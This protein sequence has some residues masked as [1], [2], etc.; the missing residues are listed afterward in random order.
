M[1]EIRTLG[2]VE[3]GEIRTLGRV[4]QGEIHILG[5][6]VAKID[7]L[8]QTY[9]GPYEVIP[10]DETQTLS[11]NHLRM[12]DD[13]TVHPIPEDHIGSGI[14][15]AQ[16]ATIVPSEQDQVIPAGQYL[17]GDQTIQGIPGDYVGSQVPRLGAK[18]YTPTEQ[19]QVI[20]PGQYITGKQTINAIPSD[21]VGTGIDQRTAQDAVITGNNVTIPEGFYG[22][23]GTVTIPSGT[24]TTPGDSIAVS[25]V[26]S[27][28][29]SGVVTATVSGSKSITPVIEP[30]YV[31]R[32]T[33]GTVTANGTN[34]LQLPVKT[35]THIT[36]TKLSQTAVPGG[37]YTTGAVM[38]DPIPDQYI[39]PTGTKYITQNGT[40]IDV[41]D[42]ATIDVSVAGGAVVITRDENGYL[43]FDENGE[44]AALQEKTNIDPTEQS[45]N[46]LPDSGYYALSRV[47]INA[48]DPEFVGSSVARMGGVTIIPHLSQ[49]ETIPAGTYLTG[50]V[51]VDP[52]PVTETSNI[53][54]GKTVVIG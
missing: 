23:T 35:E 4:H 15:R 29:N 19:A 28:N 3:Q 50:D 51:V 34:T 47:Q 30:G 52:I 53:Y 26:I 12:K 45:Q 41:R 39:V 32:G 14:P 5:V 46:I 20:D 38:V 6:K 22:Q 21:Y 27:V 9:E 43:V 36:P 33:A 54:G 31:S 37:M 2:Q 8:G 25:P 42:Y 48:I 24:A 40:D 11:T 10:T 44:S 1:P 13:F 49:T 7:W 17:E 18:S 16:T